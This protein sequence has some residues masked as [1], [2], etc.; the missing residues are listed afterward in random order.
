MCW[1]WP[2]LD[3][4]ASAPWPKRYDIKSLLEEARNT[5]L[6]D[7]GRR[8]LG[9]MD[10]MG[11]D[12][13]DNYLLQRLEVKVARCV[14]EAVGFES[15]VQIVEEAMLD[16]F[17]RK[18]DSIAMAYRKMADTLKERAEKCRSMVSRLN[19]EVEKKRRALR[20]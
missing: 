16:A 20:R 18:E 5:L 12:A 6:T 1:P 15:C 4:W 10:E 11:E 2:Q 3:L 14:G 19:T 9:D 8:L 13:D 17:K 7:E